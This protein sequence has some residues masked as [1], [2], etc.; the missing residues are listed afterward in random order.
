VSP[1]R[2]ISRL[3]TALCLVAVVV[4]SACGPKSEED[5]F[6][7]AN[8]LFEKERFQEAV[9]TYQHYLVDFPNGTMRDRAL[10]RSGETLYYALDQRG[11]ALRD[12]TLLVQKHPFSQYTAQA[13]EILAGFFRDELHD[14]QRAVLEYEWLLKQYPKHPKVDEFQ[15]QVARCYLQAGRPERAVKELKVLMERY[16]D[17]ELIERAYNELGS[18]YMTL[19]WIDQALTVFRRSVFLFPE[20]PMRP[21]LEFKMGNCLEEMQ[22][23]KEALAV[24]QNVL[25]RYENRAAVELRIE[26]LNNRRSQRLA[27][28]QPVDYGYR[29]KVKKSKRDS[30][31]QAEKI[32]KR[33]K[34]VEVDGLKYQTKDGQGG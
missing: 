1:A 27:E 15:F 13:R 20:S 11:T 16:P 17:S 8:A 25:D 7:R 26:G 4:S 9:L 12:F 23:Y 33:K 24:Y 29:P 3:L 14:Y 2:K 6:N 28:A 21:A 18:A 10:F 34:P 22:R 5:Y 31:K 32:E 19:G 30:G